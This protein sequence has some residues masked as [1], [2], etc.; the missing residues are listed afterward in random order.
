MAITDYGA[1]SSQIGGGTVGKN[2][3]RNFD[4]GMSMARSGLAT[5][6]K[7]KATEWQK[8]ALL[9]TAKYGQAPTSGSGNIASGIGSALQGLKGL[10]GAFGGNNNN[11]NGGGGG[12][13]MGTGPYGSFGDT[14]GYNTSF[15]IGGGFNAGAFDTGGG[16]FSDSAMDSIVSPD[17]GFSIGGF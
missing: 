11:N 9:E 2:S 5:Y 17:F 14:S 13:W 12:S 1:V 10:A 4:S 3:M 16:I 6:A 7:S 15:D 8:E